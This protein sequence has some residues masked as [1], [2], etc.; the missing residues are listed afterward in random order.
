MITPEAVEEYDLALKAGQKEAKER[1]AQGL[2]PNPEVLD[3]ILPDID[4]YTQQ[5]VGLVEIPAERIV[6]IKSAGRVTAFSP[7]FYPLLARNTEFAGKWINLCGAHLSEGIREPLVCFEYLGNFYVQEGNKRVS[8]LRYFGAPRIAGNVKRILP[9]RSEDP[10]I[11]AYYEFYSC[12][13][14]TY[15]NSNRRE[16]LTLVI[17]QRLS[18]TVIINRRGRK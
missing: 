5:E 4:E 11:V 2:N 18:A 15:R 7:S 10:R 13:L 17:V 1:T 14:L 6:G 16:E 3:E 9:K 8:V 12:S